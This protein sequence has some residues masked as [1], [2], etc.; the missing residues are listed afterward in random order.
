MGPEGTAQPLSSFRQEL[1]F[2]RALWGA[3]KEPQEDEGEMKHS[4]KGESVVKGLCSHF[5]LYWVV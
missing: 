1:S 3:L 5:L 4:F 2:L